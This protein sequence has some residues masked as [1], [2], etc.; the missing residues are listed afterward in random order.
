MVGG[1]ELLSRNHH[2]VTGTVYLGYCLVYP[3]GSQWVS[4]QMGGGPN[5]GEFEELCKDILASLKFRSFPISP[6]DLITGKPKSDIWNRNSRTGMNRR[7]LAQLKGALYDLPRELAYLRKPLLALAKEDQ[8]L[9]GSGEGDI[10]AIVRSLRK[11]TKRGKIQAIA[12][13][14]SKSLTE[15]LTAQPNNE[16]SWAGPIWFVV[17]ALAGGAMFADDE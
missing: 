14:H 10:S 17:G 8:D 12:A 6:S 5:M 2:K 9:L 16:S 11:V 1:Q 3:Q 15:W 7:E 13:R 4:V